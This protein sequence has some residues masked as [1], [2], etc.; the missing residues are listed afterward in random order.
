MV[1][2]ENNLICIFMNSNENIKTRDNHPRTLNL[3]SNFSLTL[4]FYLMVGYA[5]YR[6]F[7]FMDINGN[8]RNERKNHIKI[9]GLPKN[10]NISAAT[11]AR[12]TNFVPN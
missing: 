5:N 8:K 2:Y 7:I 11:Y 10:T 4:H 12:V 3:V 1:L 9:R 6:I